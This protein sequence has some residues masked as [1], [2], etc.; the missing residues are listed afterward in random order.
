ML[1]EIRIRG[2]VCVPMDWGHGP[3]CVHFCWLR[4]DGLFSISQTRSSHL[5]GDMCEDPLL[6]NPSFTSEIPFDPSRDP[7]LTIFSDVISW[8]SFFL[9]HFFYLFLVLIFPYQSC[10][11]VLFSVSH[12]KGKMINVQCAHVCVTGVCKGLSPGLGGCVCVSVRN[13]HRCLCAQFV[14][15]RRAVPNRG[16][17]SP[18]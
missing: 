12:K 2:S 8:V 18:T 1:L 16:S 6:R 5:T 13:A 14:V 10:H 15:P 3:R 11:S 4:K 17:F 9:F 7:I